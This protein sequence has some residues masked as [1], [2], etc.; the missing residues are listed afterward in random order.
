MKTNNICR[1]LYG[2]SDWKQTMMRLLPAI[3]MI[4]FASLGCFAADGT[5]AGV[6]AFTEVESQ[7]KQYIKPV[8]D[9]VYVIA[10]VIS[11]VGAFNIYHKMSNGDQDVKKTIML[12]IGGCISLIALATALPKFFGQ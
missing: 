10:A 9:V 6:G 7:V 3:C 8:R 11:I 1:K 2:Q 4:L 12:T 5:S